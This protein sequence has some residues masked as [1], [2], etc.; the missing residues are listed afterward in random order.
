MTLGRVHLAIL[1]GAA[2]LV[3]VSERAEWFAEWRAE[4]WYVNHN[5]TI[6][7]LGSFRDA[8]WLGRN[9]ASPKQCTFR[10][11]SPFRCVLVLA[12]VA[13]LGYLSFRMRSRFASSSVAGE[14]I[15]VDCFWI[16]FISFLML[17]A[18]TPLELGEYQANRYAPSLAIRMRRWG[19]LAVKIAVL[20][21]LVMWWSCALGVFVPSFAPM[22]LFFGLMGAVRWALADQRRRCP[23]CLHV[24][25]NPAQIGDP[26]RA[27]FG[28]H[29]T[30]FV[31]A[32]GHGLLYVPAARTTW[33]SAQRWQY[34]DPSWSSL[35][36]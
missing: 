23:V 27:I 25:S 3:P 22:L 34:L 5:T 12:I 19:F 10:L 32:L 30:E 2:L 14:S 6:F 35:F 15:A 21:P 33:Y 9:R 1:R 36:S 29:G 18:A 28:W 20:A 11:E 24:L 17:A 13:A 4:L 31:C 7:C 16:Y 26:S 8:F